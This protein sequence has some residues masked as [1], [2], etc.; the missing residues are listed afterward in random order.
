MP[1]LRGGARTFVDYGHLSMWVQE[2]KGRCKVG[3]T[4]SP[5]SVVGATSFCDTGSENFILAA[6][7]LDPAPDVPVSMQGK[8]FMREK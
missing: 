7:A 2:E 1:E 3:G 8:F 5:T 6:P 4:I